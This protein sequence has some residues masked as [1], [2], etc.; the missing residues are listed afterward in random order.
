[1]PDGISAHVAA[2]HDV[3]AA[4]C[5][6]AATD[7]IERGDLEAVLRL[8]TLPSL[9]L[10]D[11][12]RMWLCTFAHLDEPHRSRVLLAMGDLLAELTDAALATPPRIAPVL[13][14][15]R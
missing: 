6:E 3:L 10:P 15:V 11:G 9:K 8:S 2:R 14:V 12:P 13:R 7:Y 5:R 1:M 4:M